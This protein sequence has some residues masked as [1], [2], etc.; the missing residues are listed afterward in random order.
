MP[1][2]AAGTCFDSVCSVAVGDLVDAG[3]V[4]RLVAGEDHVRL[5]QRPLDVDAL[6]EQFGVDGGEHAGGD[7]AAALDRVRPVLQHLGLDDRDD[8]GLLA[9][10]GV[11]GER[12]R[13]RPDAV[14]ARHRVR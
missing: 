1:G 11:A 2:T 10:R 5:E 3:A 14:L 8:S 7:E 12:V 4:G 13:V 6:V 9:E